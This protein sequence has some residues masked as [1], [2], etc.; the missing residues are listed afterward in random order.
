MWN[1][2]GKF[3]PIVVLVLLP[4]NLFILGGWLLSNFYEYHLLPVLP[5]DY[6]MT[7][8]I[9]VSLIM[10]ISTLPIMFIV[11]PLYPYCFSVEKFFRIKGFENVIMEYEYIKKIFY[12]VFFMVVVSTIIIIINSHYFCK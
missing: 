6:F 12:V 3:L 7:S 2:S 5:T 1:F 8:I 10:A 4:V 11:Y 9:F